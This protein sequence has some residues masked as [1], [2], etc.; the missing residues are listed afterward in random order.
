MFRLR[1]IESVKPALRGKKIEIILDGGT[2][3]QVKLLE[4]AGAYKTGDELSSFQN[5]VEEYDEETGESRFYDQALAESLD[6]KMNKPY[7]AQGMPCENCQNDNGF[8]YEM[9]GYVIN[10]N[11]GIYVEKK[12]TKCA[13]LTTDG[14]GDFHSYYR[15]RSNDVIDISSRCTDAIDTKLFSLFDKENEKDLEKELYSLVDSHIQK[16]DTEITAEQREFVVYHTMR[17]IDEDTISIEMC[18]YDEV[19]AID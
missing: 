19:A 9:T 10:D 6:N 7:E 18:L 2:H 14:D 16:L 3:Y 5:Q 12:C 1:D 13:T 8:D 15:I 4:N 17:D 11:S